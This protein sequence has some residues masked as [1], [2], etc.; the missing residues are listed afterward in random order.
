MFTSFKIVNLS[1]SYVSL[2]VNTIKYLPNARSY[3]YAIAMTKV[4]WAKVI[5][6]T[7]NKPRKYLETIRSYLHI[8][9]EGHRN[10]AV[11]F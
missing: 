1:Y 5:V 11:E 10:Y 6:R 7:D 8:T 2:H 4:V 3:S 9:L